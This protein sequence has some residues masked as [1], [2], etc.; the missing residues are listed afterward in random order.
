MGVIEISARL[1]RGEFIAKGGARRDGSLCD[2]C[3]AI[4]RIGQ[5]KPMPMHRRGF[6]Q[7]VVHMYAYAVA[8]F[9]MDA[10]SGH[11]PIEGKSL[12]RN[13][14]KNV[15]GH[16]RGFQIENL[17]VVLK[18]G[19][20]LAVA[21]RIDRCGITD[22]SWQSSG[23]IAHRLGRRVADICSHAGR[24]DTGTDILCA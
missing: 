24:H 16:D 4:H 8:F 18:L 2:I 11:L 3:G 13:V 17:D 5:D 9:D 12:H 14:W 10:W 21:P 19:L 7:R 6:W 20:E 15:P 22:E 23:H 1:L